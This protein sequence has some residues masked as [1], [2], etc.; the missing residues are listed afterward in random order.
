MRSLVRVAEH[1]SAAV[2]MH[3]GGT[4][5][6]VLARSGEGSAK[7]V[8]DAAQTANPASGGNRPNPGAAQR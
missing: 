7:P 4:Q 1:M 5:G 8:S 3:E 2:F 6:S